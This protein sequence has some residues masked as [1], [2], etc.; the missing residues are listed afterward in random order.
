[1]NTFNVTLPGHP[2][3]V[4]VIRAVA[5]RAADLAG[6]G[7][8]RVEDLGLA[9]DESATALLLAVPGAPL[10]T[11]IMHEAGRVHLRMSVEGQTEAWPPAGWEDS[12]G[13]L[14]LE[15]VSDSVMFD[16]DSTALTVTV[17]SIA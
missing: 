11:S 7:F 8:D 5:S 6:L 10:T 1:M 17:S 14:V 13:A 3:L 16:E 12:I 2:A 15:S 9:V 4:R